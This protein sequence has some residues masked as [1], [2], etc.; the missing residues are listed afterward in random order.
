M[1][2]VAA[3]SSSNV[4]F[5][6]VHSGTGTTV[7]EQG[8]LNLRYELRFSGLSDSA[9]ALADRYRA[10]DDSVTRTGQGLAAL[11]A[12]YQE[13]KDNEPWLWPPGPVDAP[14]RKYY[15]MLMD[16]DPAP[17]WPRVRCPV[18]LFFG[19]LDANVPPRESWP[20][21]ERGLKQG[22]NADVTHFVLPQANHLLLEA[23][24]GARDEYPGL[25]AFVPGYFDRM[26]GWLSSH[27]R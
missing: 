9:V 8:A 23:R 19:E 3:D 25:S 15:R 11:Q 22:G 17:L 6:V 13:H 21:I 1:P 18:L 14:F 4:A 10:L 5:M 16:F 2:I 7:R 12:F 26:A 20:P 27:A 24:T